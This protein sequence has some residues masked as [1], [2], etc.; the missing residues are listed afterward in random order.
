MEK[1]SIIVSNQKYLYGATRFVA[2]RPSEKPRREECRWDEPARAPPARIYSQGH[3]SAA[4][5][6]RQQS[7]AVYDY[8]VQDTASPLLNTPRTNVMF[9]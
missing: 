4:P 3:A 7:H 2:N 6:R 9:H 5:V 1:H 8:S